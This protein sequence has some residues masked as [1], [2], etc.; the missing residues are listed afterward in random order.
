MIEKIANNESNQDP[1][2]DLNPPQRVKEK[3]DYYRSLFGRTHDLSEDEFEK[4][5]KNIATFFNLKSVGFTENPPE[6]LVRISTNNQI[7]KSQGKE[8][9]YLTDISQLLAPPIKHCNFNRCNIPNQQVLYCATTE[10]GAYWET[11]PKNGDVITI[12]HFKLKPNTKINCNVINKTKRENLSRLNPLQ[13]VAYML[14][15]FFIDAFSLEVSKNR[16]GDYLFSALLTSEQLFYPIISKDNI[17]AYI[18]PSVQKKK[19]GANFAIRNDL[20]LE[21]YDLI[22]VETRFILDEYENIDPE[23]EDLLTDNLISSFG[24]EKFD[25]KNGKILYSEEAAEMFKFFREL[26][27]SGGKQVRIDNP[28]G[29]KNITFNLSAIDVPQSNHSDVRQEIRRNDKVTVVYQNGTKK[30]NVKYKYV[31]L[32]IAKG[33]CK[34]TKY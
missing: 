22:G 2:M 7:L 15:E 4:L 23:S 14:E 11:K 26:Q 1:V 5:K 29:K 27:T 25:F 30:E 31:E 20:I 19:F 16:P 34:M 33:I 28:N 32:D 21:K 13:E 6:R 18:Y 8:L 12:S 24:T 10:A 17:E 9:S 3:L